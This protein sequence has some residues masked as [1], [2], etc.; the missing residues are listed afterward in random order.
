MLSALLSVSLLVA[1]RLFLTTMTTLDTEGEGVLRPAHRTLLPHCASW[2][3]FQVPASI[4]RM[5]EAAGAGRPW[6]LSP[7]L[8]TG[9]ALPLGK[10]A[11]SSHSS[12]ASDTLGTKST[13][14]SAPRLLAFLVAS[15]LPSWF[16]PQGRCT[17]CPSCPDHSGL[18][19]HLADV[20]QSLSSHAIKS[21]LPGGHLTRLPA[22]PPPAQSS[23]LH[24]S[25]ALV[26]MGK[27]EARSLRQEGN[28]L[29]PGRE[30]GRL[31]DSSFSS[32]KPTVFCVA[33]CR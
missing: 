13:A 20:S 15:N 18:A 28:K 9:E 24:S 17:S 8:S 27:G 19:R 26:P 16:L 6:D 14:H 30:G 25:L 31:P 3:G 5:A 23:E 10:P 33:R 11:H 7:H 21:P 29:N 32:F 1:E 12:L 4:C 22:P 2:V